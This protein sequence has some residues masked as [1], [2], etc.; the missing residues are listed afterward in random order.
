M[1]ESGC[2]MEY[3]VSD[4]LWIE[5]S[6]VQGMTPRKFYKLL[7]QA[8]DPQNL[9]EYPD[10][11]T[12]IIDEKT[13]AAVR[14]LISEDDEHLFEVMDRCGITAVTRQDE[15]YPNAL[16]DVSDAPPTLYIKGCLELTCDKPL[17]IV[18]TRR[19]SYDGRKAAGEFSKT[20][21]Q[22]GITVVSG[23]ARGIDTCA[24]T[25]CLEA[26]GHTIA[27][28]GNGLA[29]VYPPENEALEKRILD[30]GGSIV[31][32]LPPE[33]P[34]SRWTFPARNRII[35]A[36]SHAVLVVEGDI[37]SGAMITATCALDLGREV[38]AI[39][40]SIYNSV[41]SGTNRLIQSG[42]SPAL[43]PFDILEAMRWGGRPAEK[44]LVKNKKP[45]M[46]ENEAKIYDIL[47]N[48]CL[49]FEEIQNLSGFPVSELNSYL[50]MMLLRSIII[51]LPGNLYRLA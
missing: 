44:T 30:S 34:P 27:V 45:E 38:F 18:G 8:E 35:A 7:A 19:P 21:A 1:K 4:K 12:G 42:A 51:K 33:E 26:G 25:G 28:L 29:S 39:P 40:G 43:D 46:D 15:A 37:K 13:Y 31:S 23:L 47:K 16:N 49:S 3:T 10:E 2:G 14:K 24:H 5:L 22:N 48:E 50:T 32:E 41:A 20:L 6:A 9:W 17:G 11:F 36:L